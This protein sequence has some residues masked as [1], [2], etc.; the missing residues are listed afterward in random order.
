MRNVF[1]P[2][3]SIYPAIVSSVISAV[4]CAWIGATLGDLI[5]PIRSVWDG[6]V[7]HPS[8]ASVLRWGVDLVRQAPVSLNL[9][10]WALRPEYSWNVVADYVRTQYEKA[11]VYDALIAHITIAAAGSAAALTSAF[12]ITLATSAKMDKLKHIR[13]HRLFRGRAARNKLRRIERPTSSGERPGLLIA[14]NM[15]IAFERESR[16]FLIT[17]A[18][19][20]GKTQIIRWLMRQILERRERAVIHDTKGDV[21]E[22]FP[23]DF[24]L[25]APHDERSAVWD[26]AADIVNEQDARELADALI[27]DSQD[28]VW[29]SGARDLLTGVILTLQRTKGSSWSWADLSNLV[30]A[31]IRMLRREFTAHYPQGLTYLEFEGMGPSRTTISF[32]VT[33]RAHLA[34]IISPLA[35]AWG[36]KHRSG[37]QMFSAKDFIDVDNAAHR[38][39]ILQRAP[40][41]PSLSAAWIGAIIRIMANHCVGPYL[42]DDS[43][44]RIWFILDEFPQLKKI[45]EFKHIFD[46]GRSRGVS[47]IIGVQ[48]L[49]QM[50]EVYGADVT[51]SWVSSIGTKI[52]GRTEPGTSA[53]IIC[54]EWIGTRDVTWTDR[55][56]STPPLK[57]DGSGVGTTK[58]K[59]VQHKTIPVLVPSDLQRRLGYKRTWLTPRIKALLIGF[60]DTVL[61]AVWPIL[62]WPK[63][64]PAAKPANWLER[65]PE[66]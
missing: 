60:E 61:E 59:Q 31:D 17:G 64:R 33:M 45:E 23:D 34:L 21:L 63:L 54:S 55:S 47:A 26:I 36:E 53:N 39:V 43:D 5:L 20:A 29:P 1:L 27:L 8:T 16:H 46:K 25:L 14:P 18:T 62:P 3:R 48:D 66:K 11:E 7:Y 38:N 10:G 37:H 42:P 41:L 49:S 44:R 51:K 13:G 2:K 28:P 65:T 19:G 57:L 6:A 58:S 4:V 56:S 22:T 35:K 50:D 24:I 12:L 30:F 15:R 32:I 40:N 52:I 9:V